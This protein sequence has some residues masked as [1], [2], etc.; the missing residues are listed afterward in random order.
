MPYWNRFDIVEA[1]YVYLVQY[2]DGQFSEKYNR[3]CHILTYFQPSFSIKE[4]EEKAL[5]ENGKAIYDDLVENYK[6]RGF[7]YLNKK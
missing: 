4:K 2:H 3:M 7:V 1:Y 6:D 5:T